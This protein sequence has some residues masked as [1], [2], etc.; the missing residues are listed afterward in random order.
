VKTFLGPRLW[1]PEAAPDRLEVELDTR[2]C[3][4]CDAEMLPGQSCECAGPDQAPAPMTMTCPV[5]AGEG[6]AACAG[7][8]RVLA[9]DEDEAALVA[10]RQAGARFL[11]P[12]GFG[13]R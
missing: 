8:G 7:S 3:P 6:C 5:C 10:F 11:H 4:A 2:H 12:S 1:D 9:A 13:G